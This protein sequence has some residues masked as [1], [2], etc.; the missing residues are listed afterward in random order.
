MQEL[1]ELFSKCFTLVSLTHTKGKTPSQWN[2]PHI[3]TH[4]P[5]GPS[6][7]LSCGKAPAVSRFRDT[8]CG[9]SEATGACFSVLTPYLSETHPHTRTALNTKLTVH[10]SNTHTHRHND[11]LHHFSHT[12][13][14]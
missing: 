3:N 10:H 11:I 4:P 7:L 14:S 1:K 12:C 6:S 9:G 8:A 5:L 2:Q 13:C